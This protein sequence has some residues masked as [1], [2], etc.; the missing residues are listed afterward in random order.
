MEHCPAVSDK[1]HNIILSQ[2]LLAFGFSDEGIYVL[3]GCISVLLVTLV[4]LSGRFSLALS[5]PYD[6]TAVP[7]YDTDPR[8]HR[9]TLT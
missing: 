3:D 7:S 6:S 8:L 5:D 2:T 9:N 1:M 4:M